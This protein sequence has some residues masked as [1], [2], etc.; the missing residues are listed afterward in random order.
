MGNRFACPV[1]TCNRCY[2]IASSI[3]KHIAT[4]TDPEH[5]KFC[6][7]ITAEL[8][9]GCAT[10]PNAR[11]LGIRMVQLNQ[12]EQAAVASTLGPISEYSNIDEIIPV[13]NRVP[14][15][16]VS[17]AEPLP[18]VLMDQMDEVPVNISCFNEG[19]S[20]ADSTFGT[21]MDQTL[22]SMPTTFDE[23]DTSTSFVKHF[24]SFC[25]LLFKGSVAAFE[26]FALT[27]SA[28]QPWK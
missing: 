11:D 5:Q 14:D 2:L 27:G 9:H 3:K 19:V 22:T 25:C 13:G 20:E 7:Q 1:E 4:K 8:L 15:E 21:T 6:G 23:W 28:W 17:S 16:I 12:M 10:I 26:D 24:F 18:V